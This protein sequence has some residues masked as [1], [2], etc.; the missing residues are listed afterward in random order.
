MRNKKLINIAKR[1]KQKAYAPYSKFKVGAAILCRGGE[2]FGGC[3]IEN[4]SYGLTICAER[5]AVANAIS[6]GKKDF[7]KIC[8]V[9]DSEK[10]VYPC[11]AC[12][13][14]LSEFNPD[15]EVIVCSKTG[16]RTTKLSE[17]LP[18]AFKKVSK[19]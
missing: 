6:K 9:T 5:C 14:F 18:Y 3:N 1:F 11:G 10:F 16:F 7:I 4:A 8:V 13:Q 17:L 19:V 15:M 12:R 2:V